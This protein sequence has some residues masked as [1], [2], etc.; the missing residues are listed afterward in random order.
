M[1]FP[2]WTWSIL[3]FLTNSWL[4]EKFIS[5]NH[6]DSQQLWQSVNNSERGSYKISMLCRALS[7]VSDTHSS[8]LWSS[9]L[10]IE[11]PLVYH[12]NIIPIKL[13][14]N[15]CLHLSSISSAKR[16]VNWFLGRCCSHNN[17]LIF[18]DVFLI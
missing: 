3:F 4:R 15:I 13:Q 14:F 11:H 10:E 1:F 6:C 18:I 5:F 7:A 12:N 16:T 17:S 9:C 2:L 8:W